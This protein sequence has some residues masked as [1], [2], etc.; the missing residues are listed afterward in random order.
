MKKILFLVLLFFTQ[1]FTAAQNLEINWQQCFGGSKID[2]SRDIINK[3]NDY[4]IVGFTGSNDGDVTFNHGNNDVWIMQTD[5]IGTLIWEKSYGGSLDDGGYR[6]FQSDSN[7]YYI[8]GASCSSDGDISDDPYPGSNDY[9]IVK[10]DSSG[11]IL[12]DRILGGNMLDQMWT[13]TKTFDGG[14]LAFGWTGSEDGD[15]SVYYGLYDMWMVK[16]NSDGETEWDFTIGTSGMDVGQA[17]IQTG[18]GGYLVG[19][20]SRINEGGNLSCIPHSWKAEA[21]LVKLDSLRNI[22][23]QNCYG[24]SE[25]EGITGLLEIDDAYV[26]VAYTASNDGDVSGFHG[27]PGETCDIWIVKIDFFGN[28]IWQKCL[29]GTNWEFVNKLFQTQD[30]GFMVIG[31]TS[32]FD[33]D[34]VGNHSLSENEYD[35]WIVKLN[36]E[37]EFEWQQCIGGIGNDYVDFG[38][39]K[40]NDNNYVIAGQTDYGPSFDVECTPHAG[41]YPD[42]WVFEIIDTSTNIINNTT[43]EK[44]IKVYPNPAQD[45]VVFEIPP[46]I[47]PN[48]GKNVILINDVFGQVIATLPI[49]N[50]K[51][52]WDCREVS[53]G[54][55]I[56]CLQSGLNTIERGKVVIIK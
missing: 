31:N 19:G 11:N 44:V 29:G 42:F 3:Y 24:G 55:Y 21:I 49:K 4:L 43:N 26:F 27:T 41:N 20:T 23:W 2:L 5:S 52:V 13:G 7:S 40:M 47:P 33:G 17:I 51:T 9:W 25:D 18:D 16:L 45:Y 14:V 8:L 54:T 22:E 28:I 37:G 30:G 50:E 32:S 15:I 10:I 6:I 34:V 36:S 38:V 53:S 1:I 56:Y 48:G 35:I 12:W 46:S 39:I